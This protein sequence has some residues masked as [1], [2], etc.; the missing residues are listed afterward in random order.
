MK[1]ILKVKLYRDDDKVAEMESDMV[2]KIYDLFRS[3]EFDRGAIR[4]TYGDGMYNEATFK[5]QTQCK[6]LATVFR[7]KPLLEYIYKKE[8]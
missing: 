6:V 4:V 2:T 1:P 7:E 5:T 3:C 8:L